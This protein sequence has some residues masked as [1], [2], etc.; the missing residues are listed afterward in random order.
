MV[1]NGRLGRLTIERVHDGEAGL[2]T[3]TAA[4]AAMGATLVAAFRPNAMKARIRA[5]MLADIDG[6]P[7]RVIKAETGS[8]G[9][10]RVLLRE[11]Y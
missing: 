5:D 10:A 8:A 1:D 2:A 9:L 7:Y 6:V 4:Q 11:V 3:P